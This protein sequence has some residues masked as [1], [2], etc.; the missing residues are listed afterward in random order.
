[1]VT[2]NGNFI[3]DWKF[4]RVHKWSEVNTA[5]KMI[6][7]NLMTFTGQ[8]HHV[9]YNCLLLLAREG[10]MDMG[11]VRLRWEEEILCTVFGVFNLS[12]FAFS[13]QEW[14]LPT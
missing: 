13:P 5:I 2:D 6:P 8:G 7:G 11:F 1:V 3:L 12:S 14:L 9:L 10:L 4:D